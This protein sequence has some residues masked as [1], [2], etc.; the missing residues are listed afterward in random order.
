[1]KTKIQLKKLNQIKLFTNRKHEFYCP[2]CEHCNG[3]K[4]GYFDDHLSA[5]QE[6]KN[7]IT[8]SFEYVLNTNMFQKNNQNFFDYKL[9]ETDKDMEV[10]KIILIFI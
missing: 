8:K 10:I 9:K 4:D 7:I 5:L 2:H 1:M 3:L 6:A